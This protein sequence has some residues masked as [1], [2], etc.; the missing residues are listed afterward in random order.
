MVVEGYTDVLALHQ[1]GIEEAV[2]V[3]GTSIT[4]E[5]VAMLSG[6]VDEIVLALDADSAGQQAMLR[7]QRVAEK[8]G[9]RI[10]VARMPAGEDPADMIAAEGGAERFRELVESWVALPE[11]QV[12][13]VLDA[14]DVGSPA[15][16]RPGHE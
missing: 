13:L 2:A 12:G 10:G 7:T 9:V 3:M 14:T 16:A 11:F 15:G 4:D 1:A 6:H 8:R 5:Q